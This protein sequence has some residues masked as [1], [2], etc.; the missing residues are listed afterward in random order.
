VFALSGVFNLSLVDIDLDSL[1]RVALSLLRDFPGLAVLTLPTDITDEQ[2]VDSAV[3]KTVTKFSRI[4]FAVHAAGI[5][6]VQL[7]THEIPV[8][9][10]QRMIDKN[11]KG[12]WLCER[13]IY[14]PCSNKSTCPN[15]LLYHA[16]TARCVSF[17]L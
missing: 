2:S 12:T 14:R 9:D 6:D 4:D 5:G 11:M 15:D 8:K 1:R 10:W 7:A 16:S 3:R 17:R 13:S